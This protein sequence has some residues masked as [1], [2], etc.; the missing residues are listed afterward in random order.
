MKKPFLEST[1]PGGSVDTNRPP[2]SDL[3]PWKRPTLLEFVRQIE[4][5]FG[6][7]VDLTHLRWTGIAREERLEPET[8]KA[9]CEQLGIPPE[10][11]GVD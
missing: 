2:E 5:E 8:I 6:R 3:E 11:F 9:F 7:G 1:G 4:H 10:D